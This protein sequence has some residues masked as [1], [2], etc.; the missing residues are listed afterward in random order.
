MNKRS[1]KAFI[2]PDVDNADKYPWEFVGQPIPLPEDALN[3]KFTD[4]EKISL[5]TTVCRLSG[6]QSEMETS[7]PTVVPSK[8]GGGGPLLQRKHLIKPVPFQVPDLDQD[9]ADLVPVL[10]CKT[11]SFP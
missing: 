3:P 4:I 10:L 2:R 9:W 6:S 1:L 5:S 8:E 11:V 7:E